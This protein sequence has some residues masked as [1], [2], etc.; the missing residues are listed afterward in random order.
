MLIHGPTVGRLFKLTSVEL[1]YKADHERKIFSRGE[2][3]SLWLEATFNCE[4]PAE[5]HVL[6]FILSQ[7][8]DDTGGCLIHR[9]AEV[10]ARHVSLEELGPSLDAVEAREL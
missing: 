9:L 10:E 4:L 8:N 7:R 3:L 1:N 6:Y 5:I 2:D